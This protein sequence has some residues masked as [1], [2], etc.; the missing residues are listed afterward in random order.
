M[1]LRQ[2]AEMTS[3][4]ILG[5]YTGLIGQAMTLEDKVLDGYIKLAERY[6][7]PQGQAQG[8]A[9]SRPQLVYSRQH[10]FHGRKMTSA[11]DAP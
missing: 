10:T 2:I 6:F 4:R 9:T 1:G 8:D 7:F 11:V 5:N 3:D